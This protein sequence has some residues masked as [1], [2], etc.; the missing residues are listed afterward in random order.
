VRSVSYIMEYSRQPRD[1]RDWVG[2]LP[3]HL[4][5]FWPR[6]QACQERMAFVGQVYSSDWFP[7]DGHLA[8]QF[9]VCDDCRETRKW[10]HM[11]ALPKNASV[12]RQGV[13]VRCRSQQR[14]YITYSAVE[15]ST[16]QWNFNRRKLAEVELSDEHLRR[17]KI[18][19][20]FP[21]DGYDSPKIT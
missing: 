7:I 13:G 16:D 11:E 2:S 5:Y 10:L 21:Y 12:N 4:P 15:D 14:L 6:C 1:T 3:S 19:G 20:L 8:L 18:G 9:Y 17:D